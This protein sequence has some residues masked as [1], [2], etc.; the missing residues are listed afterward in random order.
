[1]FVHVRIIVSDRMGPGIHLIAGYFVQSVMTTTM[2]DTG[3]P[4]G[5]FIVLHVSSRPVHLPLRMLTGNH[6]HYW[7]KMW[8]VGRQVIRFHFR[9]FG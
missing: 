6:Y 8:G 7:E 5:G 1:M 2:R 4:L 9:W 3:V